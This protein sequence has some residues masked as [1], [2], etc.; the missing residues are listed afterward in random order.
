MSGISLTA[1]AISPTLCVKDGQFPSLIWLHVLFSII[2][3]NQ[4]YYH[5]NKIN[6]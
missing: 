2:T 1:Y 6:M 5:S 4:K 3:K